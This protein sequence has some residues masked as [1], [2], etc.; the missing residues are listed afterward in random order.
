MRLPNNAEI[1]TIGTLVDRSKQPRRGVSST[2][3]TIPN[4]E[5]MTSEGLGARRA[6]I[7]EGN[8]AIREARAPS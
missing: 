4:S 5:R 7:E 2:A 6:R 1:G 3:P 8:E